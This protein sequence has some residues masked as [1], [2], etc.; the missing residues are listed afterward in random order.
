M[1]VAYEYGN[2]GH[3]II[4]MPPLF[5]TIMEHTIVTQDQ[6]PD[7]YWSNW[8]QWEQLTIATAR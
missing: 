5:V 1:P 3:S 6:F 7:A 2:L 8:N 4:R